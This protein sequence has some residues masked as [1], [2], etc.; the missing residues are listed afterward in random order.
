MRKV[1]KNDKIFRYRRCEVRST[2]AIQSKIR[3]LYM[4]TC[5]VFG[6][7]CFTSFAMTKGKALTLRTCAHPPQNMLAL[8]YSSPMMADTR[9]PD[10]L[11]SPAIWP[12]S[13]FAMARSSAWT[14][15]RSQVSVNRARS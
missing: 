1:K 7:D 8:K 9:Y 11:D 14:H 15:M 2:E 10:S 4:I 13:A 6:L 3:T 12:W 5:I